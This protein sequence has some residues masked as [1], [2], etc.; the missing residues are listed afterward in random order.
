MCIEQSQHN[1]KF[2]QE[3]CV[4]CKVEVDYSYILYGH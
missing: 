4:C 1:L 3:I 2:L